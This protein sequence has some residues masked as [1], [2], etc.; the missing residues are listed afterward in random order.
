MTNLLKALQNRAGQAAK[1]TT[2]LALCGGA[3]FA[4]TPQ[5][6]ITAA[7]SSGSRTTLAGS[8]PPMARST[9]ETGRLASSTKLEGVT[10]NF[11]KSDAQEAALQELLTAQ[12]NPAS[13]LYHQWLNPDQYAARFG[14]ADADIAKVE[15]WLEQQGFT[16]S[17]VARS[18]NTISFTGSVAQVEAAFSTELH[19]YKTG[20]KT[21]FAPST[22]L[23]IPSAMAASVQSVTHLSDF[24]P[25]AHVKIRKPVA[26]PNFT[27]SQSGSHYLTP[28]DIKTIYDITP[29]YNAGYTGSGQSI[30]VV[31]QSLVATSDITKFQT[32]AGLTT[33]VPTLVLMPG[34]GTGTIYTDD[35]SES[36]LDLEYS[37]AIAPGATIYL[38]YVGSSSNYGSFDALVYAVDEKIAPIISNSYGECESVLGQSEYNTYNAALEQ[39]ASQGQTVVSA[40]GDDGSTDCYEYYDQTTPSVT[41]AVG[42]GLA[43]D[44]PASSQ[45]VTAMGGTEFPS[46]DVTAGSTT[47][48]SAETSTD[49]I[50]SA[51]SYIPEQ[52]WNDD[53]VSSGAASLGSGGGGVSIYTARPSWQT[54]VTGITSGSYRLVPDISLTASPD[55]AGFLYCSS[56]TS[57]GIT[58]SCTDGFRDSSDDYLTVAGGTSFDAPIFSGMLALINQARNS[59]GQGVVNSTLYT[60]AANAT[61]YASAF[62]DITSGGNECS[63]G[64]AYCSTAGEGSY[65][66]GTG[67]DE[68][69]GLG[70]LDFNNLLTAWPTTTTSSLAASTTTLTAA[71]STPV[72]SANDVITIA[73]ASGSSL[74]TT[75]PTGTLTVSVDG[76]TETS[77]LALS[78]GSATYTFASAVTGSH[79]I[80]AVY[81]GDSIYANSVGSVVVTVGGTTSSSSGTFVVAATNVTVASGSS[82][83]STVTVTPSGGYTGTVDW[84]LTTT[85]TLDS[86]CY[87]IN[88]LSVTGTAAVTTSLTFYTSTSLCSTASSVSSTGKMKRKMITHRVQAAAA[89]P[90]PSHSVPTAIAF[91]GMFVFGVGFL[92]RRVRS[93]RL[94]MG[95]CLLGLVGFGVSG[96][97]SSS[98]T[99]S[100]TNETKGSYTVTLTGTDSATSTITAST[101]LTLTV[102]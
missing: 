67:Y 8:H 7:I 63:S 96:C 59:T 73:V 34:T 32:A 69:S 68:A 54:G 31:G 101:T 10:I 25:T 38:V 24:R 51:I 5:A 99:S 92:G 75:V 91:A 20:A 55:N 61:T 36:D 29:A 1:W 79:V 27:S 62:H 12:Q 2:L 100:S 50:S 48:W 23:S 11:A 58:G 86:T 30:A 21:H 49:T 57:T 40:S 17:R 71:T 45:Y 93:V 3:A 72:A 18:K 53:T 64:T 87:D 35:E 15:V 22:D 13:P 14:M 28:G 90:A 76:T 37:G 43:V 60:L 44:F 89:N 26:A 102:D 97:G 52:V 4:Q 88:N 80:N 46:A 9:N 41:Q 6:R 98:T 42:E 70:S 47:Y 77:T 95:I 65:Y 94:L 74:L 81:S 16:I 82:G 33:K 39:A 84:T 83:S 56:D 66:A 19:T 85:A 78:S